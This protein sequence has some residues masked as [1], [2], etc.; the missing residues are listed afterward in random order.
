MRTRARSEAS[1]RSHAGS[2]LLSELGLGWLEEKMRGGFAGNLVPFRYAGNSDTEMKQA[3][4]GK[5]VWFSEIFSRPSSPRFARRR[6]EEEDG[7]VP[8]LSGV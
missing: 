4:G 3:Q 2:F 1:Q 6:K 7:I 8:A 5:P